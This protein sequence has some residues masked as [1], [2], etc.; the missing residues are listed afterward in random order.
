MQLFL[1]TFSAFFWADFHISEISPYVGNSC[2]FPWVFFST[3]M[4]LNY[5]VGGLFG[6]GFSFP[7]YILHWG[8]NFPGELPWEEGCWSEGKKAIIFYVNRH[9]SCS[10]QTCLVVIDTRREKS[11]I[12]P[13]G[14]SPVHYFPFHQIIFE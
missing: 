10:C 8:Q 11:F 13:F 4:S 5:D 14:Y 3:G 6:G 7:K 1:I 9:W 12:N 2:N